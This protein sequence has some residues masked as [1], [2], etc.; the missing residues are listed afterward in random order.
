MLAP[1]PQM[2]CLLPQKRSRQMICLAVA[3]Q[4]RHPV[5]AMVLPA[6]Q[7]PQGR[8][9]QRQIC[10][11]AMMA[12]QSVLRSRAHSLLMLT[13]LMTFSRRVQRSRRVAQQ[14]LMTCSLPP[15]A[16]GRAQVPLQV[17]QRSGAKLPHLLM[18]TSLEAWHMQPLMMS[19][20]IRSWSMRLQL[21]GTL[22][23]RCCQSVQPRCTR[24]LQMRELMWRHAWRAFLAAVEAK[25]CLLVCGSVALCLFPY[26]SCPALPALRCNGMEAQCD[27]AKV[28]VH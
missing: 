20:G 15:P 5:S 21:R 11:A 17:Q 13:S 18:Q 28:L 10:L 7:P 1:A 19:L 22:A 14:A 3:L 2:V 24:P 4:R 6:R 23:Q 12:S 26:P 25:F 27:R 16:P 8:A 9:V